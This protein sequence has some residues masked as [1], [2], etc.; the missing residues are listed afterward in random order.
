[1]PTRYE[2]DMEI[3]NDDEVIDHDH[4]DK[5]AD[6]PMDHLVQAINQ[7]QINSNNDYFRLVLVRDVFRSNDLVSRSW[8]YITDDGK[9]PTHFL[10]AMDQP[11]AKVPRRFVT[12]FNL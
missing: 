4:R 1:M 3:W 9:M 12:E 2:W 5:L 8:A 7:D 10:D 6:Y 11:V